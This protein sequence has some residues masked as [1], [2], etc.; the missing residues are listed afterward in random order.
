MKYLIKQDEEE[1]KE[2]CKKYGKNAFDS[3]AKV[4]R[5]RVKREEKEEEEE[6]VN[7]NVTNIA[8]TLIKSRKR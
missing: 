6:N 1:L 7:N 3:V 2:L 8:T 5:P 4:K